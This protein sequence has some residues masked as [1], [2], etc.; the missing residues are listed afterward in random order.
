MANSIETA[1]R[2]G[3]PAAVPGLLLSASGIKKTYGHVAALT[4]GRLELRP[5]SVHALCGGNGAGKSTFLSILMGLTRPDDGQ[6]DLDG[7][8]VHFGS[9]RE[10]LEAGIAIITQELR[11]ILEATVAENIF[12][13]REPTRFGVVDYP[14]L[15][16]NAQELLD[17]LKFPIDPRARAGDLSIAKIQLVEIAKAISQNSKVLIMDEPTSAIGEAETDILFEAIRS[18]TRQGVGVV[19]VSHRLSELFRIAEDYTVF[20][21]G[22]F[23]QAGKLHDID[24]EELV[25]LIVGRAV[26]PLSAD[27]REPG[28]TV[29]EVKDYSRGDQFQ[30]IS[31]KL[32]EREILGVFGLMGAG[33]SEFLDALFGITKQ[34]KGELQIDGK[35]V[36]VSSPQDAIS[37]RMALATEDRKETGLILCRPIRENIS[38]SALRK[39]SSFGFVKRRSEKKIVAEMAQAF[40]LRM[41]SAEDDVQDLSGGNQQKVVLSRCLVTNPRILLCDEPTRGID[42]GAKQAIY[43]FLRTFVADG[44]TALVVS[45][46][47]DEILQVAD[48]ILVFRRGRIVGDILAADATHEHL[49]HL[50]S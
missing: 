28:A 47:L 19:Y 29:L 15:F 46:E 35:R 8:P 24:R 44:K 25:R 27:Q 37:K 45:S 9:P 13:G 2:H 30:N 10:A 34:D 38:L 40:S 14:T 7:A 4:D 33:R 6:I 20:R 49:L 17:R 1:P 50:A 5:G 42:E 36:T 26:K 43:A 3:I 23:V 18:L 32:R 48:R 21:D 16:K 41:G 31:L 39:Y 12:L 22:A 11:P